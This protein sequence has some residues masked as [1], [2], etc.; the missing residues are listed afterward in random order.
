VNATVTNSAR[1]PNGQSGLLKNR[2]ST[3]D[4]PSGT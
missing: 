2:T 3:L 1:K 4:L